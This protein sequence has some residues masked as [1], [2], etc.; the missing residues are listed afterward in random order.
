MPN[1]GEGVYKDVGSSLPCSDFP[2]LY[3]GDG[4]TAFIPLGPDLIIIIN[5]I[6]EK[7]T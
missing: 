2:P 4:V 3:W 5:I 1:L 7:Q 6:N